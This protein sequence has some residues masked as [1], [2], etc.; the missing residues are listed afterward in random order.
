MSFPLRHL[1]AVAA[2]LGGAVLCAALGERPYFWYVGE[3]GCAETLTVLFAAAG[4]VYAFRCRGP[5]ARAGETLLAT[6]FVVAAI[7]MA[8]LVGEE[9]AWGQRLFQWQT[10]AALVEKNMQGETTIHNLDGLHQSVG[11]AQ[12][13]VGAYGTVLPFLVPYLP[14]GR[15]RD[16]LMVIV[17]PARYA[18]YFAPLFFWRIYRLTFELPENN[19]YAIESLNEVWECVLLLGMM[20]FFR[21]AYRSARARRPAP[22]ALHPAE[23]DALIDQ[24]AEE[25]G[26]GEIRTPEAA[27]R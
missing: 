9:L 18:I 2:V 25:P 3:D 19:Q 5:F 10:P 16:L 14:L 7:G 21:S 20:L 27:G 8:L 17:P 13:F 23:P 6:L 22:E 24:G 15:L 4:C 1:V 26:P 12:L 11:L